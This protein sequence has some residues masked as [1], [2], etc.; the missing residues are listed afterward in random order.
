MIPIRSQIRTDVCVFHQTKLPKHALLRVCNCIRPI[1]TDELS[2]YNAQRELVR[3]QAE[4]ETDDAIWRYYAILDGLTPAQW[5]MFAD[6]VDHHLASLCVEDGGVDEGDE[7]R[8]PH[9]PPQAE[10]VWAAWRARQAYLH[11]KEL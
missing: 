4:Y 1:R 10:S 9:I 3:R 7:A 11:A 2:L 6:A 5:N 8:P